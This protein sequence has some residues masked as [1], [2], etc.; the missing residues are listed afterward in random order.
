M[1]AIMDRTHEHLGTSDKAIIR[2]R[3]MLIDAAKALAD[4]IEPP[5]ID[6]SL[7]YTEIRSA[8]RTIASDDD[9]RLL[10]TKADS[11]VQELTAVAH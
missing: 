6:P 4:G 5:A 3:R 8:E 9:W 11:F 7:P 2:A 1:G 10:G